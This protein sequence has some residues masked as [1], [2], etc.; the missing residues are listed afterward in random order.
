MAENEEVGNP[1][2]DNQDAAA[3]PTGKMTV[4]KRPKA[5]LATSKEDSDTHTRARSIHERERQKREEGIKRNGRNI[6]FQVIGQ[7]PA[8]FNKGSKP[9]ELVVVGTSGTTTIK[10]QGRISIPREQA[11]L[12]AIADRLG[13]EWEWVRTIPETHRGDQIIRYAKSETS[14]FAKDHL[15]TANGLF[16]EEAGYLTFTNATSPLNTK[17]Q[18]AMVRVL[19]CLEAC[20]DSPF[21][22]GAGS[23]KY[24]ERNAEKEMKVRSDKQ[25]LMAQVN[26][27]IWTTDILHIESVA[28]VYGISLADS[29]AVIRQSLV[30]A[31][32]DPAEFLKWFEAPELDMVK[33]FLEAEMHDLI[34]LNGDKIEYANGAYIT[35][36]PLGKTKRE[37]LL[38]F[39]GSEAGQVVYRNLNHAL[40]TM[41]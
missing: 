19:R 18:E 27:L 1:G 12:D 36:I 16:A 21:S 34:R 14:I 11:K 39:V 4:S 6:I 25:R 5:V 37:H 35:A 23:A 33:T 13:D 31:V 17:R 24:F 2:T 41:P 3:T 30:D 32:T 38:S 28:L 20:Q 7:S 29:E 26:S 15:T 10:L 9:N 8:T 22:T 40:A